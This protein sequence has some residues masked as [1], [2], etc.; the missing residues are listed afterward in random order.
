MIGTPLL[1]AQAFHL[2][3]TPDDV[4][5]MVPELQHLRTGHGI[6]ER[7]FIVREPFPAACTLDHRQSFLDV[8]NLVNVFSP[9]HLEM[10]ALFESEPNGYQREKSELYAQRFL[11]CSVGPSG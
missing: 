9:N 7:P 2:L 3:A 4:R 8:C 6:S 10:A 1:N 5:R 11:D